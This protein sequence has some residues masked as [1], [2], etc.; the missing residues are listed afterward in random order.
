MKDLLVIRL[1]RLPPDAALDKLSED[2]ADIMSGPGLKAVKITPE[3][4]ADE[5]AVNLPRI[6][7]G[8]N[9]RDYGRL[10]QLI[11]VTRLTDYKVRRNNVRALEQLPEWCYCWASRS[12]VEDNRGI[13]KIVNRRRESPPGPKNPNLDANQSDNMEIL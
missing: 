1:H 9:R 10:R 11:D 8:F 2:F 4:Q 6:A 12:C 13:R 3:E 7:F 5:D